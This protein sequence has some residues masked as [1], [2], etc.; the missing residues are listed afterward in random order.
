MRYGLIIVAAVFLVACDKK[1]DDLEGLPPADDWQAQAPGMTGGQGGGAAD[2]H[3]GMNNPHAGMDMDNPHAGMD[4][5]NPHAGME[6]NPHAAMGGGGEAADPTKY[7]RGIIT[8][9]DDVKDRVKSGSTVF[10]MV[11]KVGPDG[12]AAGPPIAVDIK[13]ISTLPASFN[14]DGT[15]PMAGMGGT[16]EGEVVVAARLDQDGDAGTKQAGDVEGELKTKIPADSLVLTLDTV[17]Q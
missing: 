11:R 15:G 1:K 4:M 7:L 3:A 10:L 2:P 6:D 8:A 14:L 12:Q 13:T 17:R 16:F 5:D 9:A